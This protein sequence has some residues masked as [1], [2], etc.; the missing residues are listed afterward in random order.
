MKSKKASAKTISV[1]KKRGPAQKTS[2]AFAARVKAVRAAHEAFLKRKNAVDPEW[3]NGV[4]ERFKYPVVTSRHAPL[5]WR[6]DFNPATETP[7]NIAKAVVVIGRD[8][9]KI[10]VRI[11][12][13]GYLLLLDALDEPESRFGT[14]AAR[15]LARA[16]AAGVKTSA[17]VA[18]F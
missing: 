8:F 17:D 13:L 9:K 14:K 4:F 15:L 3:D 11:F 18:L 12:H 7:A 1:A 5:E 6:Y 2:G 16:Q 10:P